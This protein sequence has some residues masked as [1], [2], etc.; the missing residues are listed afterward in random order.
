M[1]VWARGQKIQVPRVSHRRLRLVWAEDKWNWK[2]LLLIYLVHIYLVLLGSCLVPFHFC[3]WILLVV[4]LYWVP[5]CLSAY[6]YLQWT[7][8]RLS[9]A[10]PN[11][12]SSTRFTISLNNS[13]PQ[14]HFRIQSP[15]LWTFNLCLLLNSLHNFWKASYP[16]ESCAGTVITSARACAALQLKWNHGPLQ[17]VCITAASDGMARANN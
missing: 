6:T 9:A 4:T 1:A 17:K 5:V 16:S 2:K 7:R 14:W 15:P 13:R 10:Y 12:F 8:S 3:C 11:S